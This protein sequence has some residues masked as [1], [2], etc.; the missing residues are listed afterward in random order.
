MAGN[1]IQH[2]RELLQKLRK[3]EWE[4]LQTLLQSFHSQYGKYQ[5][6]TL[7]LAKLLLQKPELNEKSIRER[8]DDTL[9]DNTFRMLITRLREKVFECL[10]LNVN[11]NRQDAYSRH[12]QMRLNGR[13]W[14]SQGEILHGR[15]LDRQALFLYDK[16]IRMASRYEAYS[17][18]HEA[19]TLKLEMLLVRG[20]DKKA[21]ELME[22]RADV[23]YIQKAIFIARQNFYR[24]SGSENYSPGDPH[25]AFEY[26]QNLAI[27][28]RCLEQHQSATLRYWYYLILINYLEGKEAYEQAI[29]ESKQLIR[30]LKAHPGVMMTKQMGTACLHLSQNA[31]VAGTPQDALWHARKAF[32]CFEAGTFNALLALDY[33]VKALLKQEQLQEAETVIRKAIRQTDHMAHK[34]GL[35][36]RKYYHAGLLFAMKRFRRAHFLLRETISLDSD[37][38][39]WNLHI[40]L[41]QIMNQIDWDQPHQAPELAIYRLRKYVQS[42]R[43][44]KTIKKRFQLILKV[45]VQLE[46]VAFDFSETYAVTCHELHS[47]AGDGEA[48]WHPLFSEFIRFDQWFLERVQPTHEVSSLK[49]VKGIE[50]G[51]RTPLLE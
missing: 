41:L 14:L 43:D 21:N 31:L 12:Y 1:D 7:K 6:K 35:A 5:P 27:L 17:V 38:N 19:L 45:L 11:V 28:N 16:T 22:Y 37:K 23:A 8:L 47:L 18:L 36:Q 13:K 39:G 32:K 25:R 40:R 30:H 29:D 26:E 3:G 10:T 15:G 20:E 34:D 4:T 51:L 49:Q 48:T 44:K 9:N 50:V 2:T 33:E 24:L 46:K 42:I